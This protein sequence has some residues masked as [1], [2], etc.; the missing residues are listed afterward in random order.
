[1]SVWERKDDSTYEAVVVKYSYEEYKKR[2][3]AEYTKRKEHWEK[4]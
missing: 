1:M 4:K 2:R 3:T